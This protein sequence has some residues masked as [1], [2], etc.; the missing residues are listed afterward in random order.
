[1]E[2][3]GVDIA[4]DAELFL[5]FSLWPWADTVVCCECLE[6]TVRPWNIVQGLKRQLKPGGWLWISA[7]TYGFPLHRFPLDCF[8]FGEDAYREWI[9]KDMELVDLAHVKDELGQPA[10]VAVGRA[11]VPV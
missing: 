9:Y 6:H 7:P 11:K 10:I 1:V 2:G 5:E 4:V 3:K 8:R